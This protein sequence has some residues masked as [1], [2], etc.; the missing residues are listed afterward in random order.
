MGYVDHWENVGPSQFIDLTSDDSDD[1]VI[2]LNEDYHV[3]ICVIKCHLQIKRKNLV[4]LKKCWRA[5]LHD[6]TSEISVRSRMIRFGSPKYQHL[7]QMDPSFKVEIQY[8]RTQSHLGSVIFVND[9]RA[10]LH[11]NGIGDEETIV[12]RCIG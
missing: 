1:G 5:L 3:L 9:W 4:D 8:I 12:F 6:P 10:F 7:M 2:D 11:D